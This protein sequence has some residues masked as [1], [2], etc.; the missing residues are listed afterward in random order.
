M[1]MESN[2]IFNKGYIPIEPDIY[3]TLNWDYDL[4]VLCL[5][6]IRNEIPNIINIEPDKIEVFLVSFCNFIGQNYPAIGIR[7]KPKFE[8][9]IKLDFFEI[10]EQIESWLTNIGG[11]EFLKENTKNIKGIDWKTLEELKEYPK[12]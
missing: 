1:T 10:E 9:A 11:I 7:S 3:D 8:E 4:I 5:E 2:E 6:F 12:Y